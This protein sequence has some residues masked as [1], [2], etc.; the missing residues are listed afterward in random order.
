MKQRK[1]QYMVTACC[2]VT[3]MTFDTVVADDS[4]RRLPSE[5]ETE[6]SREKSQRPL[7]ETTVTDELKAKVKVIL[8]K[9]DANN[10]TKE[11][12]VAINNEFRTADIRKGFAQRQAIIAAGFNPQT[13]SSLD[14]PPERKKDGPSMLKKNPE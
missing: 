6:H 13:I 5:Q 10:L 14:P 8:S 4:A 9:Y 11:D 1:W 3:I 12:A 7:E 2:V